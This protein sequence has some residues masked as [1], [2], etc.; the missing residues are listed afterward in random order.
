MEVSTKERLTGALLVLLALV[1]VV[2]ELLP[3]RHAGTAGTPA[4]QNP[5][6]GAPLQTYNVRLDTAAPPAVAAQDAPAATAEAEPAEAMPDNVVRM[7][8]TQ[9]FQ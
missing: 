5:E 7:E 9:P 8:R 3:G 4:A 2:P 1:I 6:D